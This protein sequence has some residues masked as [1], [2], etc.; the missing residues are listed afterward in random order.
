MSRQTRVL[1]LDDSPRRKR[2]ADDLNGIAGCSVTFRDVHGKNLVDE[3][4]KM[5]S[6]PRADLVIVDHFLDKTL[7]SEQPFA[8]G[9]TVA[10]AIKENW[11][12]CPVVGITAANKRTD[13]PTS[14]MQL[15]DELCSSDEFGK[16]RPRLK[17]IADGFRGL[18]RMRG[19][20]V[21]HFL[22]HLRSPKDDLERLA[23]AV[24]ESLRGGLLGSNRGLV[25]N[26]YDWISHQ[27]LDE[28]GFVCD[29]LWASTFLGI[30][31]TSFAKVQCLFKDAK[32]DGIFSFSDSP[33][34]WCSKL[35]AMLYERFPD[36]VALSSQV[37][38]RKLP[39]IT[40][41]DHSTCYAC[42]APLPDTVAF[43]DEA[44][45]K[46]RAMC[47]RHTVSHPIKKAMLFF[48]EPRMMVEDEQ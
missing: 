5:L 28:P 20:S 22:K 25:S 33:R 47:M 48:E 13:I 36:S 6:G 38:G 40:G 14:Q 42:H 44:S 30:K 15:Y 8:R 2:A 35:T 27:L 23:A 11:S 41:K 46:K 32:Y 17:I 34:W 24:P 29:K 10:Q 21:E 12:S 45:D 18:T 26:A 19:I 3:L 4:A 43:L 37:L 39:R 1:W 9:S 7:I 16:M 31:E